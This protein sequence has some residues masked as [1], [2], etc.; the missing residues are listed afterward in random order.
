MFKRASKRL[1]SLWGSR[2][3]PLKLAHAHLLLAQVLGFDSLEHLRRTTGGDSTDVPS[4]SPAA[5][6]FLPLVAALLPLTAREETVRLRLQPEGHLALEGP[7]GQPSVAVDPGLTPAALWS[8]IDTALGQP[9][10]RTTAVTFY[11][12]GLNM[13]FLPEPRSGSA[14]GLTVTAQRGEPGDP[15]DDLKVGVMLRSLLLNHG[16]GTVLHVGATA[17]GKSYFM[18]AV[19][20]FRLARGEAVGLWDPDGGEAMKTYP[21]MHRFGAHGQDVVRYAERIPARMVL[22]DTPSVHAQAYATVKRLQDLAPDLRATSVPLYAQSLADG[23]MKWVRQATQQPWPDAAACSRALA[24]LT[25]VIFHQRTDRW[26]RTFLTPHDLIPLM[27]APMETWPPLI[28]GLQRQDT[29]PAT[30][31]FESP[32][33]FPTQ[34]W[35]E[36]DHRRLGVALGRLGE[37][38]KARQQA[39]GA[40]PQPA[41]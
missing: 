31:A 25:G 21:V 12:S 26:A 22:A 4:P 28:E 17:S 36:D 8:L 3:A 11:H 23:L 35:T 37:R 16:A 14:M 13:T 10:N 40:S 19:A 6:A 30:M 38:A 15:L 18:D 5:A 2:P 32:T 20:R 24:G 33:G 29:A 39:A 34:P 1:Q 41:D 7:A 9:W 27:E